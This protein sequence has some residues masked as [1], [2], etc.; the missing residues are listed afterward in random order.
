MRLKIFWY[1]IPV[2]NSFHFKITNFVL[3]ISGV[4]IWVIGQNTDRNCR[5]SHSMNVFQNFEANKNIQKSNFCFKVNTMFLHHRH[6]LLAVLWE[7]NRCC[8]WVLYELHKYTVE[9][10]NK[11]SF[12]GVLQAASSLSDCDTLNS[13][14]FSESAFSAVF[15]VFIPYLQ[16]PATSPQP[17]YYRLKGRET[18]FH[19]HRKEHR[20]VYN[21]EAKR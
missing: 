5:T 8:F 1:Y 6:Q 21:I 14:H 19:T 10:I 4:I 11:L 13:V 17:V 3:K 16:E 15:S 9:E 2:H 18:K 7:H 20:V 12:A